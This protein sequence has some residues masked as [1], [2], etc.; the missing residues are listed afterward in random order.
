MV[1]NRIGWRGKR[2]ITTIWCDA[3]SHESQLLAG[4]GQAFPCATNVQDSVNASTPG[5]GFTK[6]Q[7]QIKWTGC[8]NCPVYHIHLEVIDPQ[9][10]MIDWE[11]Q[12]LFWRLPRLVVIDF[13]VAGVR[14]RQRRGGL[15]QRPMAPGPPV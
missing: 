3:L 1:P 2:Q 12:V 6:K 10:F 14:S 8:T 5:A 9:V 7:S 13:A 4:H 11:A 15:G